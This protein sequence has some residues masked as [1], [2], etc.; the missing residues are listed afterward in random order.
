MEKLEIA[1]TSSFVNLN[2]GN[3]FVNSVF[4]E[5]GLDS[6]GILPFS[7]SENIFDAFK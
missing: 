6:R 3:S 7:I 2:S 5:K 4:G 1:S